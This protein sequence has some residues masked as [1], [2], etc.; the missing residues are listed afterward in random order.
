MRS[1]D[2]EVTARCQVC[3]ENSLV[4]INMLEEGLELCKSCEAPLPG[5]ATLI[6]PRSS[7]SRPPDSGAEGGSS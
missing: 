2:F 6:L 1:P 3:G 7:G 4:S 5:D